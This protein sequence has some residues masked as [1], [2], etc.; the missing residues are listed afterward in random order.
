MTVVCLSVCLSV[1]PMPN[2]KSRM[3]GHSK[4]KISK[5]DDMGDP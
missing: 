1:C 4:L 5:K 3:E 2:T